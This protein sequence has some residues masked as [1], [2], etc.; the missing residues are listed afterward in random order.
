MPPKGRPRKEAADDATQKKE[1][2]NVIIKKP[3]KLK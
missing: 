2:I 1:I 3:E